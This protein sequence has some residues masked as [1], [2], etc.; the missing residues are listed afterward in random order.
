MR[1]DGRDPGQEESGSDTPF[2]AFDP[3][4]AALLLL[5]VRLCLRDQPE[6]QAVPL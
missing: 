1:P 3:G 2:R 4:L 5:L 6:V